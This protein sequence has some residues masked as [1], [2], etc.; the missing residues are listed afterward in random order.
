MNVDKNLV[1]ILRN[2][3]VLLRIKGENPFKADAYE[4][5][6]DTIESLQLDVAAL[7]QQNKLSEVKGFGEA[8]VK[9]ITEYVQTGK[10]E[11]YE[12]L[13]KEIPLE[14]IIVTRLPNLGPKKT[15]FLYDTLGIRTIDDLEKA[16][17]D[18]K[19]ATLKGFSVKSQEIILNGIQHFRAWKGKTQ[20]FAC[21]EKMLEIENILSDTPGVISFSVTGEIR[22]ISEIV[23][24]ISFVISTATP[25][26]LIEKLSGKYFIE[27][28][29]N[30]A[31]I[32]N[33]EEIPIELEIVPSE[34]FIW[35]LHNTT[36]S[37]LYLQSFANYFLQITGQNFDPI[38]PPTGFSGLRT[39][40]ELFNKL[41]LQYIPPELRETDQAIEFGRKKQI[42]KLIEDKDLRGVIH[43][44]T[45]WSDGHNSLEEMV[46]ASKNLGFEYIVICDHSQTAKYAN[47][48]EPER[49]IKQIEYIE[50]I[51]KKIS[52]IKILKGVESDILPDGSLDYPEEI[53]QRLDLVVASV[54]S[55]FKM[56]KNEMTRRIIYALRSPYT[57]ILGH[58]TGRLLLA[59]QSYE[60]DIKEIID[61]AADYG[62]I[63]EFNANPYRL[64]LPWE[65]LQFAKEKGVKISLNPDSHDTASLRDIYYGLKF[66]RK[67]WLEA[68]DVVNTLPFDDFVNVIHQIRGK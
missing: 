25:N 61:V 28:K 64:D 27:W 17:L 44:H 12:R 55:H 31:Y 26:I 9:K 54:H 56:N 4:K 42:P 35:V 22:R 23:S 48:L 24:K 15:K 11:Y 18:N 49:L 20:Q 50:Q 47:G 38:N 30:K 34:S 45:N 68:K 52:G 19:I 60:V 8:L 3:S 7:V 65:Y 14:L 66:L 40:S 43:I 41:N 51:S 53:L 37:E 16:C 58:P 13:K 57:T 59:R 32:Q 63:I 67:G 5:A 29:D 2:I 46:E 1:K 21:Y 39:E 62:K 33:D 36:G 6:A 10:F